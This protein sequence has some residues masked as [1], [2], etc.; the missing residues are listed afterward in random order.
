MADGV[1]EEK[2]GD[3]KSLD[4]HGE[5]GDDDG[6]EADDVQ[7]ADDIKDDVAWTSQRFLKE[8][9]FVIDLAERVVQMMVDVRLRS[10]GRYEDRYHY[11]V[12]VKSR[13]NEVEEGNR[14]QA[15]R[16]RVG[17]LEE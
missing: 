17:I 3:D 12:A 14:R 4:E 5:A 2:F 9:H 10:C 16:S 1:E 6:E 11:A 8:R 7:G 15:R 13:I